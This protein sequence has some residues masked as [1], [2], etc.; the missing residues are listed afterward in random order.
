MEKE[1]MLGVLTPLTRTDQ[2]NRKQGHIFNI[3]TSH[4]VQQLIWH[5]LVSGA[6]PPQTTVEELTSLTHF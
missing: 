1:N 6:T 5:T 2:A 3:K 4:Q